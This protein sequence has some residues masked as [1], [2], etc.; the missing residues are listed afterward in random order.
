MRENEEKALKQR[1]T[2]VHKEMVK[3]QAATK[4]FEEKFNQPLV[5]L[6][7]EEREAK[8]L[9]DEQKAFTRTMHEF[10]E[11]NWDEI[12]EELRVQTRPFM[13]RMKATK[14]LTGLQ[15]HLQMILEEAEELRDAYDERLEGMLDDWEGFLNDLSEDN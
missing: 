10:L 11:K 15:M 8:K 2:E 14:Y 4:E 6:T 1:T 5:H 12:P 9:T 3:L 7:P 13:Q